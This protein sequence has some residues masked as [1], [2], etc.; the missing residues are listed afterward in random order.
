MRPGAGPVYSGPLSVGSLLLCLLA[1]RSA[2][3]GDFLSAFL[4]LTRALGHE[5]TPPCVSLVG[6]ELHVGNDRAIERH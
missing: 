5:E 1:L 4:D 3:K 6:L 2:L